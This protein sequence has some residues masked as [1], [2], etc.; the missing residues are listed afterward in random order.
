[1]SPPRGP[2]RPRDF[3]VWKNIASK[4]LVRGAKPVGAERHFSIKVTVDIYGH[5]AMDWKGNGSF[6]LKRIMNGRGDLPG[7]DG[8]R[9]TLHQGVC[10]GAGIAEG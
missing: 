7:I 3:P 1:M 10:L 4:C 2:S 9:G 6:A 8:F 5:L